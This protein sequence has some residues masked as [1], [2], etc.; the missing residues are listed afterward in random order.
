MGIVMASFI[1]LSPGAQARMRTGSL[2][3]ETRSGGKVTFAI[4]IA[5]SDAEKA[6]GL[7][8]RTQLSDGE[9]MLFPYGRDMDVTMWM[10]NTYI[11]LDMLFIR[12]DGVIHRIEARTEPHSE[13]II[14]SQGPVMAVLE[15]AGGAAERLGIA[16]GDKVRHEFF[17]Q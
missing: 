9:G 13:R 6:K 5:E 12:S 15:I 3:V 8:F 4:E 7:M 17:A 14:A 2:V 10:R 1:S 11:P 16:A